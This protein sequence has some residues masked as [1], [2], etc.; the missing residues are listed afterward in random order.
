MGS[1]PRRT[2]VTGPM[3]PFSLSALLDT[4]T[5]S[6]VLPA[7]EHG[8]PVEGHIGP[9]LPLLLCA[10]APLAPPLPLVWL[11]LAAAKASSV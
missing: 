6:L 11:P 5:P 2:G 10:E 8:C 7:Q 9:E 1:M 4:T 3:A